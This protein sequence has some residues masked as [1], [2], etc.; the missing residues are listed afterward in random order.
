M[1]RSGGINEKEKEGRG[2]I[3]GDGENSVKSRN[4][5]SY[6]LH[7]FNHLSSTH[8]FRFSILSVFFLLLIFVIA[9]PV[10]S[11][12]AHPYSTLLEAEDGTLLSA[13]IA[14]DGQWRFPTSDSIPQKFK[15]A[16]LHF[17]DEYFKYHPGINPVSM[18]KALKQNFGAGKVKRGGSTISMQVVRLARKNKP[19]TYS[20]KALEVFLAF[21]LELFHS[22]EEILQLYASHAPF[23]GNVVGM[24]AAAWRYYGRPPETLSWAESA[25]LAVLPNSPSLIYP[26]KNSERLL[27]KRN[28]LL[29]K[30]LSKGIIDESTCLLSKTETLPGL[31][32]PLPDYANILLERAILEGHKGTKI[33]STLQSELQKKVRQKVQYQHSRMKENYIHNA[34]AIVVDVETGKTLAYIGNVDT[35]GNHGQYVDIITSKR[36]T[37][38]ILKPILYAAALDDGLI[39]PN[40]LLQ[41]IPVFLQGFAPRNFNRKFHGAVPADR[42]LARSLNVPFVFLLKDYGYERFHHKLKTSGILSLDK[43]SSYYGLSLILGGAESSLWETTSLYASMARSYANYFKRPTGKQYAE[44]DYHPNYYTSTN[45]VSSQT[46]LAEKGKFGAG[47]IHEMIKAMKMVVRPDEESGWESFASSRSIAWKTGTSYGFKDA[48]A[49]GITSKYVVGVW[50]GNADGEGRPELTGVKAAA[51]LMF[52]IFEQLD[53]SKSLPAP[54]SDLQ[55]VTICVLSGFKASENCDDIVRRN[56]PS[57]SERA[58]ACP[59]H[60]ILN[61]DEG[62]KNQ[63][64]SS[65]YPVNLMKQKKWFVLPATEASYFKQYNN[66]YQEPPEFLFSCL[67]NDTKIQFMELVYPRS[68]TRLYIPTELDG[69]LGSAIFEI[70]HRNPGATIFWHLDE[71]YVGKTSRTHQMGLH[72][73][74]GK[75][76]LH[77]V[78]DQGRELTLSFEVISD[79][80]DVSLK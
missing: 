51:P 13:K 25:T 75:H 67:E 3:E 24:S 77:L 54:I 62:E 73:E 38:S 15:V 76:K 63:V 40:Q 41:D 70:A 53:E 29:D 14:D 19:R 35:E 72:P 28:K 34:A 64:N 69:K 52:T 30:L 31:P 2:A 16:L 5:I 12:E 42:A 7:R 21:K 66:Q 27:D 50:V 78:D 68:F 44:S 32:K 1:D 55:V 39:L 4:L 80:K 37:G 26:G 36:S 43:P 79:R 60:Q 11:F 23:G 57:V 6:F 58:A 20:E 22:K 74:K 10:P 33:E 45:N 49:I 61:L 65:C 71:Q 17:E 48:W 46:T 47:A 8:R 59:Y 18:V 9:L 56:L